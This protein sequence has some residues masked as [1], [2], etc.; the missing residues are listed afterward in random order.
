M[1]RTINLGKPDQKK[2]D[3]MKATNEALEE[4]INASK[5][6]NTANDVAEKFGE[7]WISMELKKNL[8]QATLYVLGIHQIGANTL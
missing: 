8:E 4:G 6:G 1:A 2:L 3:A 7:S 5:P